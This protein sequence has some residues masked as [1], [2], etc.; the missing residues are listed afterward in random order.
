MSHP[1]Q[2]P[3]PDEDDA[4][5]LALSLAGGAC[6]P[7][8]HLLQH[9]GS[10]AA[11][12]DAGPIAWRAAGLEPAQIAAL[13]Q[14]DQDALDTAQRWLAEPRRHLLGCHD[15]DYPALL[16]RAPNPPLALYVDGDPSVMWHPAVAIVGSR[17]PSAGG[18]DNA[19]CFALALAT[20][21]IAVTSGMAAG[22][23]AAAHTAV[24][25]HQGGLTLAVVGTGPDLAYPR[26]NAELRERIAAHGAV[27]SEY[28]P[29]TPPRAGH[30]PARNRIIAGLS[31]ATVVIEAATRSGAL[32]TARLS[33]E[34]GREVFALPGS[35]HNPLARGCHRLIR[36]G[37]GLVES[38]EEV[39]TGI[40]P[41]AAEL[42]A[43]LRGR[44]STPIQGNGSDHHAAPDFPDPDYQRLWQALG[45]DPICMDS[46]IIRSGLTAAAV[47][48]M[49]LTM[50][51]DGYVAVERG[52]YTRK[53]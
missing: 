25:S 6:A 20:A 31:L 32:I 22:I 46:L 13:R 45:H 41:L 50:E 28:P 8:R 27:I 34:A 38:A 42:A 2:S 26:Q 16:L 49:L 4:A 48:S 33:S 35:I 21:G 40:A 17:A 5:L 18:R 30:F 1:P 9:H 14:P 24:L 52:R 19:A 37:A 15:P 51:L 10:P 39:L 23:D 47:S 43:A 12:L 29:G 11:A 44:L 36:D 7:R 53:T 3:H